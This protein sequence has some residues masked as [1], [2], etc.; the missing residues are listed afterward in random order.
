AFAG[1]SQSFRAPNLADLSR[2]GG[3]R[4]DEI[5]SASTSL[6]PETFLT[7]EIGVKT[8]TDRFSGSLSYY[9]TDIQDL[10]SS[11]PTGRIVDGL[12]EVVRTNSAT[13]F[14]QGI[15][16]S[17]T[18]RFDYGVE[19]FG[20]VGWAE[21]EADLFPFSGSALA[22]REPLTRIQPVIG[23][24]GVRWTSPDEKWR[25]EASLLA[26]GKAD[27]LNRN[28]QQDTQRIPPGG[29]PGYALVNLYAHWDVK[30]RVTLFGGVENLL[31]EAYRVHGSGSNEPGIGGLVG[32]KIEFE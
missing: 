20:N 22:V 2:F 17:A 31:D 12:R 23:V 7:Y 1:V 24:I 15:E 27:K 18:Y 11:T 9:Y 29:T 3:S 25:T 28:D 5:E 26:A 30:D 10:I 8:L 32:V 16:A 21:G 13:G 4:S 19:L 6:Q 14:V